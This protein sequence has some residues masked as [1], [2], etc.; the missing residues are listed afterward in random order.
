MEISQI[1][2]TY[3][4]ASEHLD[5]A[6][7]II[8]LI[9]RDMNAEYETQTGKTYDD[10]LHLKTLTNAQHMLFKA[11]AAVSELGDMLHPN[12]KAA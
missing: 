3:E 11:Q 10:P 5:D 2:S 9:L 4:T 6:S 7:N 12:N 8:Q 1:R